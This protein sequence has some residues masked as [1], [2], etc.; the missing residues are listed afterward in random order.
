MEKAIAYSLT[1]KRDLKN[2]ETGSKLFYAR[3]QARGSMD[4]SEISERIHRECTVTRADIIAVI[5]ALGSVVTDGLKSG[6]I[7]RI[8]DLG[9][10]QIGLSSKGEKEA[11]DFNSSNITKA[12][13]LFRPGKDL[14]AALAD[15]SYRQVA[16][17]ETKAK[18]DAE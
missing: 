4:I 14:T 6:E 5:T 1:E 11:S 10:L 2:F 18:N 8:G 17:K 7:V 15:L 12:R 9:S 13:I 16:K 3:V